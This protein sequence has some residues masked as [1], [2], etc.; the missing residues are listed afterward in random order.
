MSGADPA[1]AARQLGAVLESTSSAPDVVQDPVLTAYLAGAADAL[2]AVAERG[3]P[4][5]NDV[6]R[7]DH[8]GV[9]GA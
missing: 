2:A 3:R 7:E 9:G 8:R 4:D 6:G 5:A 1:E